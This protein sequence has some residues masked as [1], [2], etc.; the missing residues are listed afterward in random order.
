VAFE[1]LTSGMML[2]LAKVASTKNQLL[3]PDFTSGRK[4]DPKLT[5]FERMVAAAHGHLAIAYAEKQL[6]ALTQLRICG[7]R[8]F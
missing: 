3:D 4:P 8:E 2:E 5:A 6:T 7:F 1:S